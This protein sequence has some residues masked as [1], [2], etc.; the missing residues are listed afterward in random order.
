MERGKKILLVG[1]GSGGHITPL[2]A[3]ASSLKQ[4]D[5]RH[6]VYLVGQKNEQLQEVVDRSLV[7]GV[8]EIQAGKFRRY[9]GESV[10]SHI[11][12]IKTLVLNIRDLFRFLIGT[13]QAWQLL[14]THKP[15]I[16]WL[17]GG[18]VSVPVGFAARFLHIP[19]IT[20][21]SD[22]VPGLANRL[23]AKHARFNT[24]AMPANLYPYSPGKTIQVG[25]PLRSE[26]TL[27]TPQ[28]Q[29]AYK[30]KLRIGEQS[31]MLLV[32]GGGLGAQ[33]LN[34]AMAHAASD[35]LRDYPDLHIFHLSGHAL[36]EDTKRL[37]QESLEDATYY[38]RVHVLDFYSDLYE[39]S[40]AA[41]VVVTR[42]GAT[43]IAEFATQAK[44]C[45]IMPNPVLTGGQQ[46]HNARVLELAEAA[47]LVGEGDEVQLEH[48]VRV[49]LES[50]KDREAY[51]Q[52]LHN[53]M[54]TNDPAGK[55]AQLLLATD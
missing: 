55:V 32:T 1:G 34:V 51:A 26:F 50:P 20:H 49:L 42:A 9:H 24:V 11:L 2:L 14:R 4:L 41:D 52:R 8:F 21:D 30:A 17:K 23:T 31:R 29:L 36:F 27:V 22:A 15:D 40:G 46:V 3:V 44:A 16:I 39:L 7:D 5:P 47:L 53:T 35:L 54:A 10:L 38:D 45:V 13:V 33:R 28:L 12:D 25:I 19:Y 18:F 37:Y 6:I 48:A 43:A